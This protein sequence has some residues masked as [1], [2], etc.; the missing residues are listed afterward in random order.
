M[1][2]ARTEVQWHD[3]PD[4]DAFREVDL[5]AGA[6]W[7][8]LDASRM[9]RA[10]L[11]SVLESHGIH[12]LAAEDAANPRQRPKIERYEG[13]LFL[14]MHE[15]EEEDGQLEGTQIAAMITDH[16][17]LV[18]HHGAV[19]TVESLRARVARDPDQPPLYLLLDAIVDEYEYLANGLEDEVE[20]LEEE[21]LTASGAGRAQEAIDQAELYSIKQRVSRL[22]RYAIP[23][24]RILAAVTGG[25]AGRSLNEEVR[26]LF[27]DVHDHTIRIGAQIRNIDELSGAVL[28]LVRSQQADTL[29][30][31]NKKLS[32]WAAI[33]AAWA[34]ITGF[35]GMNL[36]LEPEEGT[37]FGFWFVFTL[38]IGVGVGLYSLFR[39]RRWL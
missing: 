2:V 16:Y 7:V 30:M 28:E 38:L 39:W 18:V 6:E 9:D 37:A 3:I 23:V 24:E 29:N 35:Y 17:V 14:V 20:R 1:L 13:H 22:R 15:L 31:I 11:R 5:K 32:A 27:Q 33:F 25:E 34:V 8:M 26:K 12:A 19:R 10:E 21:A 4:L 36:D